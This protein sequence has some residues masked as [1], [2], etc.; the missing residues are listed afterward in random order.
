MRNFVVYE[1]LWTRLTG[2]LSTLLRPTPG[3]FSQGA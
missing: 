3:F 2:L 1:E